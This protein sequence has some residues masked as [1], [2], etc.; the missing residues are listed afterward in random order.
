[1]TIFWRRERG[2]ETTKVT[3]NEV[4]KWEDQ[5]NGVS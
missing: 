1:M 3:E 4:K 5:T 2:E